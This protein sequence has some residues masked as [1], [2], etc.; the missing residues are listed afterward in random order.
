MNI[1]LAAKFVVASAVE[2]DAVDLNSVVADVADVVDVGVGFDEIAAAG[3][4]IH[5]AH[6]SVPV[7]ILVPVL[8]FV[9]V[10]VESVLVESASVA[11]SAASSP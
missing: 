2:A 11:P 5:P 3:F 9:S 6:V 4:P 1:R 7:L 10:P 8:V